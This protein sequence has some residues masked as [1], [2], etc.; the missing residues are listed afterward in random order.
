MSI[1]PYK[2]PPSILLRKASGKRF[3]KE[4]NDY[5]LFTIP[6][7]RDEVS[8]DAINNLKEN[9]K[10]IET[11]NQS[12]QD[13]IEKDKNLIIELTNIIEELKEKLDDHLLAQRIK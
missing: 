13:K 2:K 10:E 12:L 7:L 8:L 6:I 9:I 11:E 3:N 4:L 5:R 1:E